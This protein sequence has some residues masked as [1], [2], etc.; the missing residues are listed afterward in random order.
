[1]YPQTEKFLLDDII[2]DV[3]LWSSLR[4]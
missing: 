1:M 2:F 4:E 3:L